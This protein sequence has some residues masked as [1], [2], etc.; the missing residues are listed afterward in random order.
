MVKKIKKIEFKLELEGNGVVNYDDAETQ[1][2]TLTRLCDVERNNYLEKGKPRNNVQVA[3]KDFFKLAEPIVIKNTDGDIVRTIT[4]GYN[5]KISSDALRKAIFNDVEFHTTQAWCADPVFAYYVTSVHS[6][7]R[8]YAALEKKK[9]PL[10]RK[11]ALSIS[12]AI[13]DSG[14]TVTLSVG[15]KTGSKEIETVPDGEKNK[16]STSLRYKED[17]G[18][19]HYTTFGTIDVQSL[20]FLS[21]DTDYGR[22]MIR[23]EWLEGEKFEDTI[24]YKSFYQHYKIFPGIVGSFTSHLSTYSEN[25]SEYGIKLNDDFC[26]MLIKELIKRIAT[27]SINRATS[28]VSATVLKIKFIENGFDSLNKDEGWITIQS[29]ADIDALDFDLFDFYTQVSDTAS[30]KTTGELNSEAKPRVRAT[31][32]KSTSSKS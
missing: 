4:H 29:E 19:T 23:P 1:I 27:L 14:A 16:K 15:T 11:S 9:N 10:T 7:L 20:Q 6:L 22:L 13:E 3:K 28:F 17:V 31:I 8:G 26:K 24:L 21:A 2:P 32:K 18:K 5:L 12:S 30:F 25:I